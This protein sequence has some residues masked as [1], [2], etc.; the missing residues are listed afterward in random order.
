M[1]GDQA[2]ADTILAA[3][4]QYFARLT[5]LFN[6]VCS[7]KITLNVFPSV[8][9]LHAFMESTA[10]A[11]GQSTGP[12]WSIPEWVINDLNEKDHSLSTVTLTNPGTYHTANSILAGNITELAILFIKDAVTNPIPRW[13]DLGVVFW[14]IIDAMDQTKQDVMYQTRLSAMAKDHTL[15]PTLSQINMANSVEFEKHNGFECSY[16]LVDFITTTRGWDKVVAL[17]ANYA[18]MNSI[19]GIDE[20][21]LRTQWIAYLDQKY[22]TA[23]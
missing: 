12:G 1:V 22:L 6:H 4:E 21:T 10:T 7:S 11:N 17:L 15:I 5:K 13:L 20:T 14:L 9:A 18:A 23:N 19:L 16:S 3:T 8:Q 2:A